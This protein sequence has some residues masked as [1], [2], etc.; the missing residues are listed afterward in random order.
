MAAKY[1]IGVDEAGRGPLAGPVTVGAVLAPINFKFFHRI[2]DSKQVLPSERALLFKMLKREGK[3]FCVSS[4]V[5]H[6]IIDSKGISYAL[7]LAITRCLGK[8]EIKNKKV[9]VL[10][11][12]S[13]FA[14]E[15]YSQE[16]IIKGDEKIPIISAASIIAKVSR[17]RKMIRLAQK[18][19]KYNF[20][21][22]KG[23]GTLL[24]REL[25]KKHG[26]SAIHR[27]TF[28]TRLV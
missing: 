21:I 26:L 6:S 16:T 14:P 25:I 22:H 11:D 15:G 17:D 24:H 8:L 2:R 4:S 13:L 5:S 19:R 28:C 3:I 27:K 1:I 20:E 23:Y 18:Y 10:L 9:K 7:R 12:G